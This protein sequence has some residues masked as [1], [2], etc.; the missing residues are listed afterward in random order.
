MSSQPDGLSLGQRAAAFRRSIR[1]RLAAL[2]S[3]HSRYR[4][5]FRE[6]DGTLTPDAAAFFAEIAKRGRVHDSS[7]HTDPR[8][9]ARREGARELALYLMSG[10]ELDG[11]KLAALTR[12]LREHEDD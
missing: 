3:R 7:F 10:L 5:L 8:E 9:H 1:E 11:A 2:T 12:Q 6:E 4:R